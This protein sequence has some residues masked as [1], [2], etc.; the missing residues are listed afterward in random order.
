MI[1]KTECAFQDRVLAQV[2]AS[3]SCVISGEISLAITAGYAFLSGFCA[4]IDG[5]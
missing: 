4:R 3:E 2:A 5:T 1:S